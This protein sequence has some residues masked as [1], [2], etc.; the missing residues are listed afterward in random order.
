[1]DMIMD[2]DTEGDRDMVIKI[3]TDRDIDTDR[4]GRT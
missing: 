2:P 3:D 4:E 1:M